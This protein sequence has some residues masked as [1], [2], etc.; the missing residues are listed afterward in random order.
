MSPD[1]RGNYL[2][3]SKVTGVEESDLLVLVGTNPKLE[4]PVFNARIKKAVNHGNLK[5]VLIGTADD[6][7]YEY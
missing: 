1:F 2:L 6:L 3:N 5:V 4:S 7:T